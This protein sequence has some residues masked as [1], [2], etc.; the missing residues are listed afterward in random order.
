MATILIDSHPQCATFV[1]L[2]QSHAALRPGK[3]LYSFLADGE[4]D[5]VRMTYAELDRQARAVAARLQALGA[6]GDRVLLLFPAGLEYIRAI[7]GCFYAGMVAV[8]AYPPR[9]NRSWDRVQSIVSDA[10]ARIALTTSALLT[11]LDGHL[12]REPALRRLHWLGVES[13]DESTA[14]DWNEPAI[15]DEDLALLQY[16]SG[17]TGAPKGVM[18]SHGNLL[19]N[20]RSIAY[21]FGH[22]ENLIG[23]GWLP[24]YHD[25]GLIGNILQSAYMGGTNYVMSPVAFLQKP[26][27]WLSAISR[28]RVSTSGGP[29]F[30][31]ELCLQIPEEQRQGLDLSSWRVAFNGAEPIRAATLERFAESY[32]PYGFRR[33]ACYPCYG[34]AEAT[35]IVSGGCHTQPPVYRAV[36]ASGLAEHRV[37]LAPDPTE[38]DAR[39]LVGCGRVMPDHHVTIV[40]PQ[41]CRPA[42]DD[43]VGE[44]W[45]CGPSIAQGYWNKPEVSDETFRAELADSAAGPFLRTGDLGF[46]HKGELFVTGRQKDVI[47]IRGRNYY[48]QDI[49]RTVERCHPALA[50]ALGATFA[51]DAGGRECLVVTQEVRRSFLRKLPVAEIVAAIREAV[52]RDHELPV[53]AVVLLKTSSIAKT[54]SGKI[55]RHACRR[56]FLDGTLNAVA[57]WRSEG[58]PVAY[59]TTDGAPAT[60][61]ATAAPAAASPEALAMCDTPAPAQPASPQVRAIQAWLIDRIAQR[62]KIDPAQINPR[63]SFARYGFD[64]VTAVQMAHQ[65]EEWLKRPVEP[66]VLYNYPSPES[67]AYHLAGEAQPAAGD[68]RAPRPHDAHDPIAVIGVGCRFPGGENPQQFWQLLHEGRDAIGPAPAERWQGLPGA[69][70]AASAPGGFLNHVEDFDPQ[71]FGIAPR[72]AEHMDPQQRL[73]LEVAWEALEHAALAPERLAGSRT[74]VFIGI[75]N[76]DYSRRL[77]QASSPANPYLGTGSA[78]SIAANRLSYTLDLHGPSWAVDTACSSSLVAVHQ[79]CRSLRAGECEL[80]LVGGVNL[81]LSPELTVAFTQAGMLAGDGRCKTFDAAADGYV[82]SE[83]C[84]VVVLKPLSQALADGDAVLAV[85]RG[86]AVNQDGRSNGLTAPHGPSQQAVIRE[87]LRDAGVAPAALS[88]VEAH[89]TGTALGDP[90]ELNSLAAVLSE[91]R[92]QQPCWIGSVKTNVGHMESAAGIA[93][94]I[95]VVLALRHQEIP[96][97]LHF[98]ALNPAIKLDGGRLAI[99][100]QAQPWAAG[101]TPRLAG[102]SAFGFGGTNAHVIVEEAPA[103]AP[104]APEA[105]RPTHVLTLSARSPAA[106]AQLAQRYRLLLVSDAQA[107]LADVCHTANTARGSHA[108]RAAVVAATSREA[109]LRLALLAAGEAGPG[110]TTAHPGTTPGQPAFV[111]GNA[112]GLGGLGLGRQLD[113]THAEFHATLVRCEAILRPLLPEPLLGVLFP[114]PGCPSPA[115]EPRYMQPAAFAF[116]YALAQLWRSWGVEPAAIVAGP[117]SRHLAACLAGVMNLEDALKLAALEARFVDATEQADHAEQ[118]A[119]ARAEWNAACRAIRFEMPRMPVILGD[120]GSVPAVLLCSARW[121]SEVLPAGALRPTALQTDLTASGVTLALELGPRS[122]LLESVVAVLPSSG[123]TLAALSDERPDWEA[124][125]DAVA[126][127]YLRGMPINWTAFDRPYNRRRIALPTYPFQRQRYWLELPTAAPP[128]AVA[129]VS[130]T[131]TPAEPPAASPT[132]LLPSPDTIRTMVAERQALRDGKA[133]FQSYRRLLEEMEDTSADFAAAALAELGLEFVT[134]AR[135]TASVLAD[136]L[137]VVAAQRRL[138]GR[139]LEMLA[140]TGLLR[141]ADEH[142]EVIAAGIN[143]Q[144]QRHTRQLLGEHPAAAAELTLLERCGA[145]LADVLCGRRDALELLAPQGDLS[146]LER[147]YQESH[148]ARVIN[149]LLQDAVASAVA[150]LTADRPLRVLE[151]GGGTGGTTS[152][153]LPL[154][155]AAAQ[156]TFTDVSP[157]FTLRAQEKF[158]A[159]PQLRYEVLDIERAPQEQRFA[160]GQYDLVIAANVLH[161]TSDLRTSLTHVRQLLAPEGIV[162]LLEGT[163]RQRWLD[164]VFGLTPGWWRFADAPLRTSYPLLNCTQWRQLLAEVGFDEPL[165]LVPPHEPAAEASAL[166]SVLLAQK[167]RSAAEATAA[168]LSAPTAPAA[169]ASVTV[170]AAAVQQ[171]QSALRTAAADQRAPLLAGY[172]CQRLAEVLRLPAGDV[173]VH[174]PLNRMGLD[175]LMAIDLKSRIKNEV[176]VDVPMVAFMDNLGIAALAELL[177]QRLDDP[178]VPP[179]QSASPSPSA[180]E[181]RG[182][183][184]QWI[185]GEL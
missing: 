10:D 177:C 141:K 89:G 50:D 41:T 21:G 153:V 4:A 67:L 59:A 60:D 175:S 79:A 171:F 118:L 77:L 176:G 116:E 126:E 124:V 55:Q 137:G 52:Y 3:C 22:T 85:I 139:L 61:E 1:E 162:L 71:F 27:R 92:G 86:S 183:A 53:D 160:A 78:L 6:P 180:A 109:Q 170:S 17:S 117:H 25:M 107:G 82:R 83:G 26:L 169:A 135:F 136:R 88:Y 172:L 134:G 74:G 8:P 106:L 54:S 13:I 29:N 49:E 19:A 65:L 87:A 164:L 163:A 179:S 31:Y 123:A 98:S 32:A 51:L 5:E 125:L 34:L 185:E 133:A 95:K 178:G 132:R 99:P 68:D 115:D 155:P 157:L 158:A 81:I 110:V 58:S 97:H 131:P 113:R 56:G 130:T 143:V 2:M 111:V 166:Q 140:E 16:T 112:A 43:E 15:S 144:P 73:L 104:R 80:A 84:G 48:P 127:L 168:P 63:L 18:V 75:S 150:Q 38:A 129:V 72:E 96:A 101:A 146:L 149:G 7:Y 174:L 152:F 102:V 154:L 142:W 44:I 70:A 47:I 11:E 23:L 156:Y 35:L 90:I 138:F 62:L 103:E 108:Y 145:A 121:W 148:G 12:E 39:M 100:A 161:A 159:Y 14:D 57:H 28:Y 40:N 119:A 151:I 46:F 93:G 120:R 181:P 42:A 24:M 94:L 69:A 167:P 9:W 91:G 66:T 20:Q 147:L 36:R 64:S 173:D 184:P 122:A 105:G 165:A 114:D 33:E 76:F 45:V 128:A 182:A 30:A 37:E